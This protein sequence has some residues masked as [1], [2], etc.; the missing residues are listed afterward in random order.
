MKIKNIK[1][2]IISLVFSISLLVSCST[3]KQANVAPA[4]AEQTTYP[5]ASVTPAIYNAASFITHQEALEQMYG[6]DVTILSTNEA[7]IKSTDG[8]EYSIRINVFSCYWDISSKETC[9]VV[10][11]RSQCRG[12]GNYIDG[13]S[14]SRNYSGWNLRLLRSNM[15]TI[16]SKGL[17]P[18]GEIIEIGTERYAIQFKWLYSSTGSSVEH[19]VIITE[20]SFDIILD[21]IS[22]GERL[23]SPDKMTGWNSNL[24]FQKTSEKIKYYDLI[25]TYYGDSNGNDMPYEEFYKFLDGKYTLTYKKNL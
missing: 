7:S 5:V 9:L 16:A 6:K 25:V 20:D 22:R 15:L 10:T 19:L 12:C 14:F 13:A 24:Y 4:T 3:V 21:I 8:V 18:R 11:D 1:T 17:A 2:G 23:I